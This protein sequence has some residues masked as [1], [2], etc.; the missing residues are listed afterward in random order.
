MKEKEITTKQKIIKLAIRLFKD[1]GYDKITIQDICEASGISK[2]TFYYYFDSKD[3][4]VLEFVKIPYEI[5]SEIMQEILTND[6]PLE[7]YFAIL[8]PRI[9]YLE[10]LGAEILR[11][12]IFFGYQKKKNQFSHEHKFPQNG[13]KHPM[14]EVEYKLIQQAQEKGEIRNRSD[15]IELAKMAMM[16]TVS[17]GLRWTMDVSERTLKDFVYRNL[18][19]LF[20][21]EE[22]IKIKLIQLFD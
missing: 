21:L 11:Q 17:A 15:A 12:L 20:D 10:E 22:N 9:E 1:K 3:K 7:K 2:H 14:M 6:S 13:E 19:V 18:F 5:D 16:V 8:N 4:I